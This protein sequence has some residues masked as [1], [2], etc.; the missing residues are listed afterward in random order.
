MLALV[1]ALALMPRPTTLRTVEYDM[2]PLVLPDRMEMMIT[3][4]AQVS[5]ADPVAIEM[6]KDLYGNPRIHES[7]HGV[8]G[9]DGTAVERG[10]NP[11]ERILSPAQDGRA[12]LSYRVS[13][14]PR[15]EE[16]YSYA[17]V[18]RP[19]HW[20]AFFCQFMIGIGRA[21]EVAQYTFRLSGLPRGYTAFSS[22]APGDTRFSTKGARQNLRVGMIGLGNLE[23]RRFRVK[24][25]PVDVFSE[26]SLSASHPTLVDDVERIVRL[27]RV[28]FSDY[29][30][31]F[32]TISLSAR[33]DNVA[34]VRVENAFVC[35]V[36]PQA[37]RE[38]ILGLLS[39]EMF[40][41]W[42]P[43]RLLVE[44]DRRTDPYL[45]S[46]LDE[47]FTDYFGRRLM[48]EGGLIDES[49]FAAYLNQ[50]IRNV[51][52]NPH[53]SATYAEAKEAMQKGRYGSAFVKLGYY[54]G[55]L[56]AANWDARIRRASGG[57]KSLADTIRSLYRAAQKSEGRVSFE[58]LDKALRPYSIDPEAEQR[59]HILAGEPIVPD[60]GA[61]GDRYTLRKRAVPAFDPGFAMDASIRAR[62]VQGVDPAGPAFRAGLRDGQELVAVENASRFSNAFDPSRPLT[63][64]V[65][66]D[67]L[68]RRILY[69][70]DGRPVE[71]LLY[72][73]RA[74]E[75][76]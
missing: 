68:E 62:M 40:H 17:P 55:A 31:R 50:T 13:F 47:G 51:S 4:R 36:Q 66:T 43:G 60:E 11:L 1:C 7:I 65:L 2:R 27:Q 75:V 57:K 9:L 8:T 49:S 46:W 6:P 70:P 32:Y 67:G 24:G 19:E 72:S 5:G 15:L 41:N 38:A 59:R 39:H 73:R 22:L 74:Q 37:S 64:V 3:V 14:D 26:R 35:F 18:S 56:M 45:F 25:K 44:P 16:T 28:W 33:P 10:A 30:Q 53:R 61:A 42:L 23:H 76:K 54:R 21:D 58:S 71:L 69:A 63:V 12:T 29:G 52:D 20:Q 48:L 34:G